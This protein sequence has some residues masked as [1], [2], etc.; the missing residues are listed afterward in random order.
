M[1]AFLRSMAHVLARR[2]RKRFTFVALRRRCPLL[3][4]PRSCACALALRSL[5]VRCL[6]GAVASRGAVPC[7]P[8]APQWRQTHV[9]DPCRL[10]PPCALFRT[11]KCPLGI[12]CRTSV[13]CSAHTSVRWV[14]H[15]G[16]PT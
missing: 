16:P 13:L 3:L 12:A 8:P 4:G 9:G 5:I 11:Y 7:A 2:A 1:G 10:C 14:L 6:M 15:A